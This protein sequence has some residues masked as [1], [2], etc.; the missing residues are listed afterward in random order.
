MKIFLKVATILLD[1]ADPK[2]E[3]TGF[4]LTLPDGTDVGGMLL[5][6]GL[7]SRLVGSVTINKKRRPLDAPIAEGD[8]VAVIPA[9]SGG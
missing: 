8:H 6:L 1:K 3:S 4:E 5:A 9:I 7:E 2:L